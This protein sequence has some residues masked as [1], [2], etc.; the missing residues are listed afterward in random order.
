MK[1]DALAGCGAGK[2]FGAALT[3]PEGFKL[4]AIVAPKPAGGAV[5]TQITPFSHMATARALKEGNLTETS[6]QGAISEVSQIVGVNIQTTDI[7]DITDDLSEASDDA[8]ELA[9]F[10]AGLAKILLE[11]PEEI[12]TQLDKLAT[13]FEDGAFNSE[14]EIGISTILE[15]VRDTTSEAELNE[16]LRRDL[17]ET[18]NDLNEVIEVISG[19]ISEDGS[20]DPK[21]SDNAAAT[22]VEQAKALLT[23]ARTFLQTIADNYDS[24]LNALDLDAQTASD[25]LSGESAILLDLVGEAI[26]QATDD[27]NARPID[28]ANEFDNPGTYET[29]IVNQNTDS[30]GT[31]TSVF[32]STEAGIAI[33]MN[34]TLTGTG[35]NTVTISN[36]MLSTSL[37]DADTTFGG[38]P[39]TITQ[40]LISTDEKV[41]LTGK[42]SA[43]N[44]TSVTFEEVSVSL[45][46][47]S[48]SSV[49]IGNIDS[50]QTAFDKITGV[51]FDGKVTIKTANASFNGTLGAKL[52]ALTDDVES[53]EPFSISDASL[54]GKFSSDNGSFEAS[55]SLD[56]TNARSFDV[57]GYLDYESEIWGYEYITGANAQFA[58]P[59]QTAK[60]LGATYGYS[61]I[62]DSSITIVGAPTP[63]N[64]D[65]TTVS[66]QY[67]DGNVLRY[68]TFAGNFWSQ[69]EPY[70]KTALESKLNFATAP[71]SLDLYYVDYNALNDSAWIEYKATFADPESVDSFLEGQLGT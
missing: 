58:V 29:I 45:S 26:A 20:F 67:L 10:S 40:A 6:V 64:S 56:I 52:V 8:K 70:A 46:S 42:V 41:V 49:S 16:E 71:S 44:G 23:D 21:P 14:D 63:S 38:T 34:G 15:A 60:I 36:L 22:E 47:S 3:L 4:N 57:F 33:T 28:L 53:N 68:D 13:S 24:P 7:A 25:V 54:S 27:L 37:I 66:F 35:A 69:I 1:C 19:Q 11:N 65:N 12:A 50:E 9:L 62:V 59:I 43:N 2:A 61:N 51:E 30:I 5:T 31:L 48:G 32:S 55:A 39:N 18:I 17:A